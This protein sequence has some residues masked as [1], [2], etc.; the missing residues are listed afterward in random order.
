VLPVTVGFTDEAVSYVQGLMRTGT[1]LNMFPSQAAFANY[2]LPTSMKTISHPMTA[3]EGRLVTVTTLK[4]QAP[5]QYFHS[6]SDDDDDYFESLEDT[7]AV[8]RVPKPAAPSPAEPQPLPPTA[9]KAA[10][11][12]QMLPLS[13]TV[14]KK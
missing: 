3:A 14:K 9:L 1:E 8:V 7:A 2:V 12:G 11:L 10:P 6:Y 4:D 5:R 13:T